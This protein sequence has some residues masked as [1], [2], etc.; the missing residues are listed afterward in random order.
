MQADFAN[1]TAA[2]TSC[3]PTVKSPDHVL[4]LIALRS[5]LKFDFASGIL[6]N[7]LR[8]ECTPATLHHR[9]LRLH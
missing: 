7:Y 1:A 3:K 2:L 5:V 4:P 8:C 6:Q 9:H